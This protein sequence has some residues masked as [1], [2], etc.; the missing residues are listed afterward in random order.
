MWLSG[1]L[2]MPIV[3]LFVYTRTANIIDSGAPCSSIV[4]DMVLPDR[5]LIQFG[6]RHLK[7]MPTVRLYIVVFGVQGS[8]DESCLCTYKTCFFSSELLRLGLAQI[9]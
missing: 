3:R 6:R 9:T 4:R 5:E 1:I 8:N 7:S 2:V